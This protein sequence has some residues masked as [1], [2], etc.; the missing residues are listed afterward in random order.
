M[1]GTGTILTALRLILQNCNLQHKQNTNLQH[2]STK[3]H[4]FTAVKLLHKWLLHEQNQAEPRAEPTCA[5]LNWQTRGTEQPSPHSQRPR[6][7]LNSPQ[8]LVSCGAYHQRTSSCSQH[9]WQTPPLPDLA[10]ASYPSHT[11]PCVRR[12]S[13][14]ENALERDQDE[15][16]AHQADPCQAGAQNSQRAHSVCSATRAPIT[17]RSPTVVARRALHLPVSPT[18]RRWVAPFYGLPPSA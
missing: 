7:L 16:Q 14:D 9:P 4:R 5:A 10:L 12:P 15:D 18:R 13:S 11:R 2:K 17:T 1:S 3:S 6:G 8:P